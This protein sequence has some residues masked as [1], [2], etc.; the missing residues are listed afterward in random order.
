MIKQ[1]LFHDVGTELLFGE[2]TDHA[3]ELKNY[4]LRKLWLPKVNFSELANT[5]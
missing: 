1:Y 4:G 3:S 5:P 2:I